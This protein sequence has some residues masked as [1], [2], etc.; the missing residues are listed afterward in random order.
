MFVQYVYMCYE[1]A[2]TVNLHDILVHWFITLCHLLENSLLYLYI[3]YP[4]VISVCWYVFF[5]Y[6]RCE[7]TP[8][9]DG[10]ECRD[11]QVR[12]PN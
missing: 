10:V 6:T 5:G 2:V 12:H 9:Q 8:K 1:D 11:F 4:S 7:L 3:I